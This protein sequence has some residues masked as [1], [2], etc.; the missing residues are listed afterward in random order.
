MIDKGFYRQNFKG[1]GADLGAGASGAGSGRGM[2]PAGGASSGG[3]Y[4][5][6]SNRPDRDSRDR[7]VGV[8]RGGQGTGADPREKQD[9]V[10]QKYTGSFLDKV[11]GGGYR[12]VDPYTGQFQSRLSQAGG[13]GKGILGGI[14]GLLNPAAGMLF[15]AAGAV[16]GSL[17]RFKSSPTLADYFSGFNFGRNKNISDVYANQGRGSGLRNT[18]IMTMPMQNIDP[19]KYSIGPRP[20]RMPQYFDNINNYEEPD[21]YS[22]AMAELTDKQKKFINSKKFVLEEEM[23]SPQQV[24]ET[25]TDPDLGIY[26]DGTFGFGAQ[27]PTTKEEYNDYLR[28]LGLTQTI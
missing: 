10:T 13:L 1:G 4:G 17:E 25:I 7:D 26:D 3:N 5:G 23:I 14:I 27:E 15:R 22:N 19:Y 2:G 18:G 9:F 12:N 21:F 20:V 6:N 24:F 28:S 8:G 11:L 16:P